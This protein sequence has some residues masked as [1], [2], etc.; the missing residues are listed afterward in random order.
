VPTVEPELIAIID[1]DP[2]P[3]R[4]ANSVELLNWAD[5]TT[6][7]TTYLIGVI[8]DADSSVRIQADKYIYPRLNLLPETF[9]ADKLAYAW[10]HQLIRPTHED[11]SKALYCLTALIQ[12]FPEA[13]PLVKSLCLDKV[14]KLAAD[15]IIDT[16]NKPA[17]DL[18]SILNRAQVLPFLPTAKPESNA[19]N[20][21]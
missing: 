15:S 7:C 17:A 19:P 3:I 21:W 20:N 5:D 12:K 18:A 1:S 11:R 16:I 6:P 14:N 9:P 2:D 4:R 13:T 8:D 10:S